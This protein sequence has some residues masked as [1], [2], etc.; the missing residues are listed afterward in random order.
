MVGVPGVAAERA[1]KADSDSQGRAEVHSL[2]FFLGLDTSPDPATHCASRFGRGETVHFP[3]GV[4]P[5]SEKPSFLPAEGT[6]LFLFP[7]AKERR[8]PA[9]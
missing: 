7:L 2:G 9:A 6:G 8:V 3:S 5:T 1:A 4:T